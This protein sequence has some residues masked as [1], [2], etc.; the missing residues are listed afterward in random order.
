MLHI[1]LR[2]TLGEWWDNIVAYFDLHRET[3][4]H[5]V[6]TVA[7]ALV[8]WIVGRL[9]I[10][11]ATRGIREGIPRSERHIRRMNRRNKSVTSRRAIQNRLE[12]ERR[13][14]RARTLGVALRSALGAII[15]IVTAVTILAEVNINIGPLLAAAGILGVALGFG[16]QS[17]VKDLLSGMFI[18]FEDQ[19]GV[20]DTID[21][22]EAAGSVEE[23][24]LRVTRLRGLDG[25][26][27][28]V[29]NGEI[30]RVG[31]KSRLWSRAMVE[32]RVDY[33]ADVE[34]A[35]LALL[36]A[37]TT[38]VEREDLA[39]YV[40]GVPDVPGV[41]SLAADAVV[42]RVFVQVQ[43][44]KQWDVQRAIRGEIQKVFRKQR[45]RLA[46]PE[47]RIYVGEG[48]DSTE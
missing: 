18:L 4:W 12:A 32:V 42:L 38:A 20:G 43:P 40:L 17:L 9:A 35:R 39:K 13:Q 27:W 10:R 47:N 37:A 21:L 45:V 19:Y 33:A 44:G 15:V 6:I 16:A 41:E 28:F 14:Q 29:P 7:A 36:A 22:G 8:L 3:A 48:G 26:V 46:V 5:I 23:V 30:R 1:G 2:A 11:G 34:K 31:N 25:T 24:G